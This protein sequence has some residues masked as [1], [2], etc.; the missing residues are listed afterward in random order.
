MHLQQARF[1]IASGKKR[2]ESTPS[3]YAMAAAAF[4]VMMST[5]H[6]DTEAR[7]D[8]VNIKLL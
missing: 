1:S 6:H 8:Q 4:F 5:C 3:L 7:L 2:L